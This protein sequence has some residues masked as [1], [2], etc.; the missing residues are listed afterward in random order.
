M[1][2]GAVGVWDLSVSVPFSFCSLRAIAG[3][4]YFEN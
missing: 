4:V 3:L 2:F 1:C